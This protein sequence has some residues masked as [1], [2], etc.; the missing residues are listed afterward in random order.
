MELGAAVVQAAQPVALQELAECFA[1]ILMAFKVQEDGF[2]VVLRRRIRRSEP[3][4]HII[5]SAALKL[6]YS[7]G[8]RQDNDLKSGF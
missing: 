3:D 4:A 1:A 5:I 6:E 8:I 7:N 2:Q